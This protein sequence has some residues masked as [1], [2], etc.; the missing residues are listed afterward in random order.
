MTAVIAEVASTVDRRARIFA[1]V[2]ATIATALLW[3]VARLLDVDFKVYPGGGKP[4]QA[5]GFP[6]AVIVA[7]LVALAGWGTLELLERLTGRA[8]VIWTTLAV[9]VLLL[10]AMPILTADAS[11]GTKTGLALIHVAVAAVLI[12]VLPRRNAA[13]EQ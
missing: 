8:R 11:G 9:V 10:S 12:P 5:V 6:L 1:V 4:A 3:G 13:V 2:G 7:L